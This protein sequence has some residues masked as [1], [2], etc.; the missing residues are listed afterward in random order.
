MRPAS[1]EKFKQIYQQV[2]GIRLEE[3]E[4]YDLAANLLNLYRAVYLDEPQKNI[5]Q[6]YEKK[7][8]SSQTQK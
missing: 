8:Q 4:A 5:S 6:N 2:Y 3:Q 1:L 7:P